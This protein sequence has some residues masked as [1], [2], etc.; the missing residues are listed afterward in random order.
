M[1]VMVAVQSGTLLHAL[2]VQL[3]RRVSARKGETRF[4]NW[5]S[6]CREVGICIVSRAELKARLVVFFFHLAAYRGILEW[7]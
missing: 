3:K 5:H 2:R 1:E 4:K 6:G 7:I